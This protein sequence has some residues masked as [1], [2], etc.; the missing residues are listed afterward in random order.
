MLET[1]VATTG[2]G[3]MS[4]VGIAIIALG[5]VWIAGFGLFHSRAVGK[6]RASEQWPTAPGRVMTSTVV[7]EESTDS[8]GDTTTWYNPVVSYGYQVGGRD[9][10]GKRLRFG[11]YRSASRSKAE[12]MLAAYQSGAALA[13][14]YNPERPDECVLE[15][16]KPGPTY[17]LMA[18][19]GLAFVAAGLMIG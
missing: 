6:A 4:G 1:T 19:G 2:S 7:E 15:T 16:R 14:R 9:Y 5:L 17:L 18:L 13:V 11:N 12:A 3:E 10:Q 8:E